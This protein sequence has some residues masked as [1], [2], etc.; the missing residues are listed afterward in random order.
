[1]A[2]IYTKTGDK[3]TTSLLGGEKVSK[4]SDR[5]TSYGNVDELNA[6]IALL[7]DHEAV[8]PR[9]KQQLY[10]I[11]EQLFSLGSLLAAGSN[12][13]GFDLPQI[14]ATEITQLEQWM[15][16]YD[17][18]LPPLKNFILPGGHT[19]VSYCHVCRTV[20]RRAERSVIG[21]AQTETVDP[22]NTIFLN[23]LSD[24]FFML[25][26]KLTFDLKIPETPWVPGK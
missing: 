26:R 17:A 14:T 6:F 15:D 9:I 18:K 10:W 12:F 16:H 23:R 2:K 13:S 11:Q 8:E 3:G 19:A 1:M 4:S 20:C 25:A 5:I 22:N 7:K 21:L 24:Y